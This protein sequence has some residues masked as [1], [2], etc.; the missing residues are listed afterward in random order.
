MQL[1]SVAA[2]YWIATLSGNEFKS[3][4]GVFCIVATYFQFLT[5]AMDKVIVITDFQN[6]LVENA[7]LLF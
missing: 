2:A 1:F 5:K 7:Q 6:V 4:E 3:P